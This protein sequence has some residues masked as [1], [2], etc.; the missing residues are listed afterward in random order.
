MVSSETIG[1]RL[2]LGVL[3][4]FAM[5]ESLPL[6]VKQLAAFKAAVQA[7]LTDRALQA[8]ELRALQA[9]IAIFASHAQ[10]DTRV[11]REVVAALAEV[12]SAMPPQ[13]S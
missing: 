7:I 6:S 11:H 9:E 13:E 5:A 3:R 12:V 8:E 10:H 2:T 4:F 1:G